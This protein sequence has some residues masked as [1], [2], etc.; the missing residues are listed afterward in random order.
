MFKLRS[1][2]FILALLLSVA[3]RA[4]AQN[5]V[6][7]SSAVVS[8]RVTD[9]EG[10]LINGADVV[11]EQAQTV[12]ARTATDATGSFRFALPPTASPYDLSATSGELGAWRFSLKLE[13]GGEHQVDLQ[14]RNALNISGTV[15]ALDNSPQVAICVQALL[16]SGEDPTSGLPAGQ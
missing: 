1:L 9:E 13:P 12:V 14:L 7:V 3:P 4:T 2:P 5:K 15:L 16:A 11:V 6:L 8:G 10:K